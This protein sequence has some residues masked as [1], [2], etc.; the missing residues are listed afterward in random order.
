MSATPFAGRVQTAAGPRFLNVQGGLAEGGAAPGVS[1]F[2]PALLHGLGVFEVFRVHGGRAHALD[3]H[4]AR[5]TSAASRLG[6]ATPDARQLASEVRTTIA[7]AMEAGLPGDL[8][9]R[10]VWA[11]DEGDE[12]IR[13]IALEPLPVTIDEARALLG[14]ALPLTPLAVPGVKSLSYA[15]QILLRRRA[16]AAGADVALGVDAEGLL[17]ESAF[18]N[19]FALRDDELW[20][21][22]LDEGPAILPGITRGLVCELA[23]S[24]GLRLREEPIP[25]A[26]W[27]GAADALFLSSSV[28]GLLPLAR[29]R[30]PGGEACFGPAESFRR[31]AEAYRAGIASRLS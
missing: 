2:A 1:L 18:A 13:W 12:L 11:A 3:R 5:L 25:P 19:V 10:L 28:A 16:R 9:A 15:P 24:L 23:P 27:R 21:A 29:V 22:P 20:T 14:L 6:L 31:V 4:L 17:W 8:R 26:L 30:Y 7:A